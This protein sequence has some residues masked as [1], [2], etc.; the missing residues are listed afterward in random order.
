[1]SNSKPATIRIVAIRQPFALFESRPWR[2]PLNMYETDHGIK[3]VADL[4]GI[5]L[6]ELSVQ[7]HPTN[8]QISGMRQ[9]APPAG[10]RRIQRIE[11][12]SGP[13]HIEVPLATPIDPDRS[14]AHYA[15]G[16]LDI[17]LPFAQQVIQRVVVIRP[18]EVGS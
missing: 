8:L 14:E 2:P 16:L 1:M 17:W 18:G 3:L 6:D 11:I 4:A 13:F 9:V 15:N 10:L 12:T 7:V 5:S